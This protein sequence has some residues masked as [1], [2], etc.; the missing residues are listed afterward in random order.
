MADYRLFQKR[1]GLGRNVIA[2]PRPYQTDN[3]VTLDAI[4]QFAPNARGAATVDPAISDAELEVL[5]KG[6][7][8]CGAVWT[9]R[10]CGAML[11]T[12]RA[13]GKARERIGMAHRPRGEWGLNWWRWGINC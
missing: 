7:I 12:L 10:Q 8:R 4:K 13:A 3:S 1:L 5:N 11:T 2:T 6:G 9:G